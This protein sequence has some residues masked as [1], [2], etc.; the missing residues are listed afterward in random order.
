MQKNLLMEKSGKLHEAFMY[1]IIIVVK[2]HICHN[3]RKQY[4]ANIVGNF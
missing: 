4:D 3:Y 1:R 2:Y